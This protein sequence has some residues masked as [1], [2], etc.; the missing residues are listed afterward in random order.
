MSLGINIKVEISISPVK[1]NLLCF[2]NVSEHLVTFS[3]RHNHYSRLWLQ[4]HFFLMSWKGHKMSQNADKIENKFQLDW[5]INITTK[6]N[7]RIYFYIWLWVISR[8]TVLI[9]ICQ[10][11]V[12]KEQ[13]Y[14]YVNKISKHYFI[15]K[16]QEFLT[17]SFNVL[18]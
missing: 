2:V 3:G 15:V 7:R 17:P 13:N 10:R 6:K 16:V 1:L 5:E 12:K 9:K 18:K 14:N 11:L 8:K 4:S